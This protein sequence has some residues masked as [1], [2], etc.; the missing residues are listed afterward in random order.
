MRKDFGKS[1]PNDDID[2]VVA[3]KYFVKYFDSN[4]DNKVDL[5]EYESKMNSD[6]KEMNKISAK[7]KPQGRKRD[8]GL[9]WILDF[10]N[11]GIVTM[12]ELD[13][14]PELLEKGP[15]SVDEWLESQRNSTKFKSKD[16][17]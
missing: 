1:W 16:E 15:G 9:G 5:P 13:A 3:S 4:E 6:E 7:D 14:A 10:N 11:D 17:L 8:P 12:A 2:N